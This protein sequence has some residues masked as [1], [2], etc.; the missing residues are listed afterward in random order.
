MESC[1]SRAKHW[2]QTHRAAVAVVDRD[3]VPTELGH[4]SRLE[5]TNA[6]FLDREKKSNH[7]E[8]SAVFSDLAFSTLGLRRVV[9]VASSFTVILI[10]WNAEGFWF[11]MLKTAPCRHISSVGA[12]ES[13]T[14]SSCFLLREIKQTVRLRYGIE[15]RLN[16]ARYSAAAG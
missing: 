16:L 6:I 1:N 5:A 13:P 3:V 10:F 11:N 7:T 4:L 8:R 14:A 2:I 12:A 9:N 15:T